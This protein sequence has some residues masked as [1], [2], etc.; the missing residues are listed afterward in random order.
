MEILS[1]M[2]NH[3]PDERPEDFD[4]GQ[5][6]AMRLTGDAVHDDTTSNARMTPKCAVGMVNAE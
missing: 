3:G 5:Q 6:E 4:A 2:I 1:A